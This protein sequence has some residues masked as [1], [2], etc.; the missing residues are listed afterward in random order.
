MTVKKNDA[1][2]KEGIERRKSFRL[3][4]EKEL[5]DIAWQNDL[6]IEQHKKLVCLDFSRGGVKLDSDMEIPV[7]TP[8]KATFKQKHPK[9]QHIEGKV[10]RCVQQK[11]G[12]F[13]IALIFDN[14]EE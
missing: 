2:K 12:W 1:E 11:N 6:G 3:D 14:K 8:I 7:N 13:E 5:I 9:S 10:L 4:M